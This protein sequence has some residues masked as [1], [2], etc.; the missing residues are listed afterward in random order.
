MFVKTNGE[1]H[2]LW[3]A[4]DHEGEVLD[5]V[6]TKRRNMPVALKLLEN[7]FGCTPKKTCQAVPIH[8]DMHH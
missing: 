8:Y 6:V 3:R 5:S 7:K 2:Y 1:C 4:V